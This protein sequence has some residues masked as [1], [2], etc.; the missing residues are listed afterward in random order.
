MLYEVELWPK[1]RRLICSAEGVARPHLLVVPLSTLTNWE[2]EFALWAP[3]L[4]VVTLVGNQAARDTIR[5]HELYTDGQGRA[6]DSLQ[7]KTCDMMSAVHD[8][9]WHVSERLLFCAVPLEWV[10][11]HVAVAARR[12]GVLVVHCRSE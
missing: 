12:C 10:L 11:Q 4:N 3:H 6:R 2:R 9:A 5:R 1:W 8:K 7:V